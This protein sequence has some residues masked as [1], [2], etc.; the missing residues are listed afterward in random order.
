M[1][2]Y[3]VLVKLLDGS[4]ATLKFPT[5]TIS[6]DSLKSHLHSLTQ[7][8]PH[9]QRLL[10]GTKQIH[11]Q[12]LITIPTDDS[13]FFTI[14]LLLRLLGGKGGFGSLLRGAANKAGQKKTNNFDA[15]RDMN[16]RRLRHVNA[17]KKLEEWKAEEE[18][19]K[20]ER[21]AE[22][23]LKKKAKE[24][25]KSGGGDSEK[26]VKKYREDSDRCME[27]VD[28]AVRESIGLYVG[29]KRKLLPSSGPSLKRM[30]LWMKKEKEEESDSDDD[31]DD[32]E[33]D[34]DNENGEGS[35]RSVLEGPSPDRG[36]SDGSSAQSNLEEEKT[37][38]SNVV[39]MQVE[40]NVVDEPKLEIHNVE[41]NVPLDVEIGVVK[42][43]DGECSSGSSPKAVESSEEN[44][45]VVEDS[46]VV[47]VPVVESASVSKSE[48]ALDFG[49]YNSAVEMEVLGMERLKSELQGRGLKCGGTLQERAARLFLLKTTPVEKLPK[50][51]LAKK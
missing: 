9:H 30:K 26:Y 38:V 47:A 2:I 14:H 28:A 31:D 7:I 3:N 15:C 12:T 34:D 35:S 17:E 29:A 24:V 11:N 45:S 13:N 44:G 19:R 25:K 46:G 8:P 43:N 51:L 42:E 16:G 1:A 6:V 49:D 33:D 21:V 40:A 36:S 32:D 4:T 37:V 50:K 39:K 10:T 5:P 41:G 23:F 48:K 22:E 27:V 18:G 20:L